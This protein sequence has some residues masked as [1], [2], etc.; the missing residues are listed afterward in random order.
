M[1]R[2]REMRV[3][4][5]GSLTTVQ[6]LGRPGL[7]RFGICPSGAMD[8][9]ALRAAN[10]MVGNAETAAAL[11]ITLLGP[12]L[13]FPAGAVVA[14]AGSLFEARV[15]ERAI[16]PWSAARID[17]GATLRIGGSRDSARCYLAIRGGIDVP[18]VLGSR[19]TH[20]AAGFGGFE[21]R[22]LRSGDVLPIG[23]GAEAPLRR[24][25]AEAIE[26]RSAQA[27]LR[28][29]PGPQQHAFTAQSIERF[30]SE[31]FSVSPRSDRTG[32]RLEGVPLTHRAGADLLPEGLVTGSVQVPADGGPIVLGVDHPATGGYVK[33]ATV[34]SADLGQLAYAK[35]GDRLRFEE[36]TVEE[37][38][39]LAQESAS[40][41]REALEEL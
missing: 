39:R 27:V 23:I 4:K 32:I 5:P 20:L 31:S 22:A 38:R 37:A 17:A 12:T 7:G 30:A 13:L 19:S 15:D 41:L 18:R 24:L 14:V 2:S 11:E 16:E 40:R 8:A 10:R 9:T 35:P 33:I 28:F 6:D 25:R 1:T 21:G 3:V 36:T 26:P 29:V 34:I